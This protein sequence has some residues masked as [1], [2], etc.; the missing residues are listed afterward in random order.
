LDFKGNAI[1]NADIQ[2][3][4]ITGIESL[5][6]TGQAI[7]V[8]GWAEDSDVNE[9]R[10]VTANAGGE[11]ELASSLRLEGNLLKIDSLEVNSFSSSVDFQNN[12]I[13]SAVLN[14]GKAI[15]LSEVE[16]QSIAVRGAAPSSVAFFTKD[17]LLKTDEEFTFL[18]GTLQV[19]RL[20][21]VEITGSVD[22][23]GSS[24]SNIAIVS[25]SI[26]DATIISTNDFVVK[27]KKR[28]SIPVFGD[29][30]SL[31][32]DE[33]LLFKN[34]VLE[35]GK[36]SGHSVSGAVNFGGNALENAKLVSPSIDGLTELIVDQI[37]L[38]KN[39]EKGQL[40]FSGDDGKLVAS[41]DLTF[42]GAGELKVSALSGHSVN[43][44]VNFKNNELTNVLI[45]SGKI[46]GLE[47]L[48]AAAAHV[49]GALT[50]DGD[51][52]FGGAVTVA[53]AVIGSGPYIDSSDRRF[54]RDLAPVEG[55]AALAAVRRLRPVRYAHRAEEFP[56]RRLAEGPQLGFVAQEVQEVFPEVVATDAG[57]Y[58]AV[59]YGRLL[60]PVVAALGE[61]AR[62]VTVLTEEQQSGEV[63]E[64]STANSSTEG[65]STETLQK[66][67]ELGSL[68]SQVKELSNREKEMSSTIEMLKAEI[69]ELKQL[70]QELAQERR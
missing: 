32:T 7:T 57:G 23:A 59:A 68:R 70:V 2:G 49:G 56:E 21:P 63:L 4:K 43:G 15:D 3:G 19:R 29:E 69:Q 46:T 18:E 40:L 54:K 30:G 22:F 51:A 53:G 27:G 25:G 44:P 37:S 39:V 52:Y 6:L 31:Q 35:V 14:G 5:Q 60:P 64:A 16:T 28:G 50:A 38:K 20:G 67:A 9:Q 36:I 26:E 42:N 65:T 10:V 55:A 8:G 34:G 13:V 62:R 41:S 12:E 17:G 66:T 58:L 24:V 33:H 45:S 1:V 61:L 11:L 48:K 47:E